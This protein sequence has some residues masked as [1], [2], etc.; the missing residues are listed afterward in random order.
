L[1][2]PKLT[3]HPLQPF[4]D[5]NVKKYTPQQG[6]GVS[7]LVIFYAIFDNFLSPS[8]NLGRTILQIIPEKTTA[9]SHIVFVL[10]C[11]RLGEIDKNELWRCIENEANSI[12]MIQNSNMRIHIF[13]YLYPYNGFWV[14]CN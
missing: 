13:P 4:W 1:L 3:F 14:H 11:F 12:E 5:K 2:F 6:V 9:K 10:M 7:Y 8:F